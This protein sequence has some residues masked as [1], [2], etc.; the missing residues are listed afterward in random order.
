MRPR[1]G[2][3]WQWHRF[4]PE[5]EEL[6][7]SRYRLNFNRSLRCSKRSG[8]ELPARCLPG[9]CL[10]ARVLPV[11]HLPPPQVL[12]AHRLP[13]RVLPKREEERKER[14]AK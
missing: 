1:E 7:D 11:R 14:W 6:E 4:H 5:V 2:S 10:P 8:V 9:R 3:L 13:V 12:P